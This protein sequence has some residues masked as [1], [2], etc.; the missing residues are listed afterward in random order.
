MG[1]TTAPLLAL[2][3]VRVATYHADA[4]VAVC[5]HGYARATR[6]TSRKAAS[7]R[8]SACSTVPSSLRMVRNTLKV[9]LASLVPLRT[10]VCRCVRLGSPSGPADQRKDDTPLQRSRRSPAILR[11]NLHRCATRYTRRQRPS[12][13]RY[14]VRSQRGGGGADGA[15][16][17]HQRRK[18]ECEA[19]SRQ[20]VWVS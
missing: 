16:N 15:G 18:A 1:A 4:A 9:T 13:S 5:P 2:R 19:T 7:K 17:M 10:R 8:R 3:L 14:L 6:D 11:R 12:G 20:D